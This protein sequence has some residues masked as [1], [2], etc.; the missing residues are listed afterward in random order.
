ML[1]EMRKAKVVEEQISENEQY[2]IIDEV[3][4]THNELLFFATKIDGE[5][6]RID[7]HTEDSGFAPIGIIYPTYKNELNARWNDI[8]CGVNPV[9]N[10]WQDGRGNELNYDGWGAAK[11][12]IDGMR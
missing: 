9:E 4:P 2:L 1:K 10:G 3:I 12:I 5:I 7:V 11:E 8:L 6:A